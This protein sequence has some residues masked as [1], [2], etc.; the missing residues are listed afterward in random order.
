MQLWEQAQLYVAFALNAVVMRTFRTCAT[1]GTGTAVR[2]FCFERG[3]HETYP[4]GV[5]VMT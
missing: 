4:A 2:R 5:S 3:C 1:L